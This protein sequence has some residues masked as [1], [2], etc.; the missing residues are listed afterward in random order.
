[1]SVKIPLSETSRRTSEPLISDLMQR[2]LATPNLISLAAGFVDQATLPS[3]T[4]QAAASDMLADPI[5]GRRSLQYG[6]TRGDF[7]LRRRVVGLLEQDEGARPGTFHDLVPRTIITTGSQQ[8]LYLICEVLL[9]PGDIVLVEAPTYFVFLGILESRGVRAVGVATDEGGLRLDSLEQTLREIDARGELH[10]VKFLYTVPEHSNPTGLSLAEDRRGPLVALV[11]SWSRRQRIFIVEDAAYRGLS[12]DGPDPPSLWGHDTAGDTVVLARTFSK[13]F[14]PGLKTGFG[15]VPQELLLPILNLKGNHDFGSTH[16]AQQ[17]IDR[18]LA[19][20]HYG[21]HLARLTAAYRKKREIL[22]DALYERM[23]DL[24]GVSWTHPRGGLYVWLT[25]PEGMDTGL[26]GPWF[27]RCL[28]HG[29]LYVP[30][31]FAFPA[32][33]GPPASNTA[34]LCYGVPGEAELIEGVRRLAVALTE[35]LDPVA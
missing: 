14:S 9:D 31:A 2:A 25:L 18:V 12:F 11:R 27:P 32:E 15:V 26:D 16:F 8:F 34:R 23:G 17:L 5:E 21:P 28:E 13:T 22:L 10:R 20:G 1:M 3:A 19:D 30:G 6:T 35:C 7:L 29:V 33:P 24:E 4:V